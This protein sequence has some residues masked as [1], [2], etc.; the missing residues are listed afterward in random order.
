MDAVKKLTKI[1]ARLAEARH[2]LRAVMDEERRAHDELRNA[3]AALADHFA[4]ENVDDLEPRDLHNALAAT[5]G[6]AEQP[7]AQRREGKERLVRKLEAERAK[8]LQDNLGELARA[9]EA[10]AHAAT[11]RVRKA[12]VEVEAAAREWH[13]VAQHYADLLR[14]VEGID[15]RDVPELH[16]DAVR[17][18]AQRALERGIPTPFPGSL[19]PG[20][21]DPTIRS[22]A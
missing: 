7:W 13:R 2:A 4:H 15:G 3:E 11:E 19:Y 1:D 8:F 22:A 16:I 9:K 18:E 6:R 21:E 5:R 10:A 20:D 14:P 12:L 17:L